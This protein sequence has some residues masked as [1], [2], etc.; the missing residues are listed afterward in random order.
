MKT[1]F[2]LRTVKTGFSSIVQVGVSETLSLAG[3]F[4]VRKITMYPHILAHVNVV[5][6]LYRTYPELKLLS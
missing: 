2:V 3:P 6:G 5:F 1:G 4:S